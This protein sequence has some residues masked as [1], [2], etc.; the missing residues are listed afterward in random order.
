MAT[1]IN[2]LRDR[3]SAEYVQ[4]SPSVDGSVLTFTP[5]QVTP[6]VNGTPVKMVKASIRLARPKTVSVCES[7]CGVEITSAVEL[8]FNIQS[9][10]TETL[11]ALRAELDRV[12]D[13]AIADFQLAYGLVPS[14]NAT[15]AP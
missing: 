14:G 5:R 6:T 2:T 11:S 3:T 7:D 1:Y 9:G 8:S 12:V 15:F 4:T 13:A 10:D